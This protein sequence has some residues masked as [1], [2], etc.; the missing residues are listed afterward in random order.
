MKIAIYGAGAMGS[1]LGAYLT[2]AGE[3]IDLINHNVA[4]IEGMKKNGV[5]IIGTVDWVVPVKALLPQEMKDKYDIVFL[6]TKQRNNHEI[7]KSLLPFLKKDGV[8]CTMQNGIPELSVSEVVGKDRTLGCAMAWG[9]TMVG[10]GVVELTTV[11]TY[12][13]LTFSMGS[14]GN[15][16]KEKVDEIHR[17][18]SIMG[19]TTIEENFLGARWAKLLVNSAFSGLSAVLNAT[20]GEIATNKESRKIVQKIIKEGI[21]VAKEANIKVEPIQ[22]KDIVKLLDY[23]STFKKWFSFQIIPIAMKKHRLLKSS[24]LQDILKGK[25]CEIEAINGVVCAYGK[26]VN[27]PTPMND[28]IVHTVHDIEDGKRSLGWENLALF[29]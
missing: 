14:F 2:K 15:V 5:K 20:F 13:T 26:K 16:P 21:D 4:H 19:Q 1:V 3:D 6:M 28:L 24:M 8:I 29:Q 23:S 25:K 12:E 22:G 9:A 10:G 11:P 18:L 27:V 17:L 7:V